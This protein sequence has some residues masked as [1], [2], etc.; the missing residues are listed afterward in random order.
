LPRTSKPSR[1]RQ[2][3]VVLVGTDVLV[4]KMLIA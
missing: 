4:K 2:D 1:P 3:F